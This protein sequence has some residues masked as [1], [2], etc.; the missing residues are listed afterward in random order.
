MRAEPDEPPPTARGPREFRISIYT[1]RLRQP[2]FM[3]W[4]LLRMNPARLALFTLVTLSF[5]T[6]C[7]IN[8]RP[9]A[10][11]PIATTRTLPATQRTAKHILVV[12]FEDL[13]GAEWASTTPDRYIPVVNWF[14]Q[15]RLATS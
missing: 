8:A 1:F 5:S 10:E 7:A 14:H 9:L 12:P 3:R 6:G 2:G 13:R 15:S 4:V 11:T